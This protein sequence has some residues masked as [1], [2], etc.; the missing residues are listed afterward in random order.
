MFQEEHFQQLIH[1][2]SEKVPLKLDRYFLSADHTFN[3][4]AIHQS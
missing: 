2:G 3:I 4:D 1:P